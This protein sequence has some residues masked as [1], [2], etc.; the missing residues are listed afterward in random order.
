MSAIVASLQ[1]EVTPS[2]QFIDVY[3][4]MEYTDVPPHLVAMMPK[5][6]TPEQEEMVDRVIALMDTG[7]RFD[8]AIKQYLMSRG[9]CGQSKEVELWGDAWNDTEDSVVVCVPVEQ[10]EETEVLPPYTASSATVEWSAGNYG[11]HKMNPCKNGNSCENASC[12]FF[13][14]AS[15]CGFHAGKN[16]DIRQRLRD[17]SRNPDYNK[18]MR[19]GKG[20]QCPFDHRRPD[21]IASSAEASRLRQR[22][23]FVPALRCEDDMYTAFPA[24]EWH[25][26]NIFDTA[27]LSQT[28]KPL[29]LEGLER[30]GL[31][32]R[33]FEG[34]TIVEVDTPIYNAKIDTRPFPDYDWKT[35]QEMMFPPAPAPAPAIPVAT[36]TGGDSGSDSDSEDAFMAFASKQSVRLRRV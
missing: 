16:I 21:V 31:Q 30:G 23:H 27:F 2:G 33:C 17:G 12:T 5:S 8:E 34:S 22:A 26:G 14:G 32:Y 19:C 24:L 3:A 15:V 35:I 6:G 11:Y 4:E 1:Q 9:Q 7:V 20:C 13:H 28:D 10:E 25:F 18:P 29:L 36:A